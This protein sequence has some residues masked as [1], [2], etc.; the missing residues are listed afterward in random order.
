[1]K[2]PRP[3]MRARAVTVAFALA[4]TLLTGL[5]AAD[6]AELTKVRVASPS[7]WPP[8]DPAAQYGKK[9]GFFA[10]EGIDVELVAIEGANPR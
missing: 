5:G 4:A 8:S 10:D 7:I 1:M 3:S 2:P 9:L 6:A